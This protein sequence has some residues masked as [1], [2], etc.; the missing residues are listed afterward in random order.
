MCS[1]DLLE[2]TTEA[3]NVTSDYVSVARLAVMQNDINIALNVDKDFKAIT[4]VANDYRDLTTFYELTA[5]KDAYL[6]TAPILLNA[7]FTKSYSLKDM[8]YA[9]TSQF[10][11]N[12]DVNKANDLK[13]L[14]LESLG[15]ENISYKFVQEGYPLAEVDQSDYMVLTEDGELS[16]RKEY[17]TA[18]IGRNPIIRVN[19]FVGNGHGE[20]ELVLSQLLKI[21]IIALESEAKTIKVDDVDNFTQGYATKQVIF[22]RD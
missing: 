15:F 10:N 16:F 8:M 21:N 2:A 18:A 17:E 13:E 22:M 9:Y 6:Q 11:T 14:S 4:T 20:K 7:V 19:M 1:S 3:E 12:T 5:D